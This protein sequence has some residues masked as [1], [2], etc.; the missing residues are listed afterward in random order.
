MKKLEKGRFIVFE[1]ID[2][3]GKTMQLTRTAQWLENSE[4]TVTALREPS[5]G[6]WGREIRSI[7][8]GKLPPVSPEKELDLFVHDRQ[9]N[10]S[11]NIK[12]ALQAGNIVLQ[13]RYFYSTLAYQGARGFE[14]KYIEQLHKP[15][16]IYP[17]LLLI[18]DI[19][20]AK[21]LERI[22]SLRKSDLSIFE[23]IDFLQKV[24]L[25]YD[26]FGGDF[27]IHIKADKSP[28]IVEAE[29]RDAIMSLLR[30]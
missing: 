18:F 19:D 14:L 27:V 25:I 3:S 28:E 24:K 16:I 22:A 26:S 12:P 23:R 17:D 21:G 29:V 11:R 2:G 15:F 30:S 1:G 10:I 6:Q 7:V 13:D 4:Y 20:P 8:S 9:D 5:D